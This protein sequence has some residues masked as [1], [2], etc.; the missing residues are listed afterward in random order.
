MSGAVLEPMSPVSILVASCVRHLLFL[1]MNSLKVYYKAPLLQHSQTIHLSFKRNDSLTI[2]QSTMVRHRHSRVWY[3]D[4]VASTVLYA[5]HDSASTTW[6]SSW[7]LRNKRDGGLEIFTE[8]RRGSLR[9]MRLQEGGDWSQ[10]KCVG[11]LLKHPQTRK[12]YPSCSKLKSLQ[13]ECYNL[14]VE[15]YLWFSLSKKM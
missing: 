10:V 14:H 13:L 12:C 7:G 4:G 5:T 9:E 8:G 3:I 1:N 15:V 11:D 2:Q 6:H